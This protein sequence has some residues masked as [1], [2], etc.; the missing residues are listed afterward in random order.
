MIGNETGHLLKCVTLFRKFTNINETYHVLRRNIAAT[1]LKISFVNLYSV[2]SYDETTLIVF[3]L[4]LW[5]KISW[6][7][8]YFDECIFTG[9]KIG[10]EHSNAGSCTCFDRVETLY[11]HMRLIEQTTFF[12]S[13]HK[14]SIY[15][16]E[17]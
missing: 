12:Y 2:K 1:S 4:S 15:N 5:K 16:C 7:L 8:T 13:T 17:A 9:V 3:A 11:G 14:I 10:V 6:G